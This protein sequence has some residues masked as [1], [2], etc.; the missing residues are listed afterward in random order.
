MDNQNQQPEH[1]NALSQ[2]DDGAGFEVQHGDAHEEHVDSQTDE[3]S[4]KPRKAPEKQGAEADSQTDENSSDEEPREAAENG[5]EGEEEQGGELPAG[6]RKRIA[7]A[8]RQRADAERERDEFRAKLE[9]LERITEKLRAKQ[10]E[11]PEAEP[12]AADFRTYDD[13]LAALRD[14]RKTKAEA[15]LEEPEAKPEPMAP[16]VRE[17]MGDFQEAIVG[18]DEGLWSDVRDPDKM[19][20]LTADMIVALAAAPDTVGATRALLA[21]KAKAAEIA[22]MKP[23]ALRR[24]INGLRTPEVKE[25]AQEEPKPRAPAKRE[26]EARPSMQPLRATRGTT[27][28]P[29]AMDFQEYEA[30]MNEQDSRKRHGWS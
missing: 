13:Y 4:P 7:R 23:L 27:R 18:E 3:N 6:V 16:E 26:G 2:D 21:D 17:A 1:H 8:A 24:A 15:D 25:E 9:E 5:E 28:D 12:D 19:P 30:V 14:Y 20:V 22:A 11:K 10:P 29:A